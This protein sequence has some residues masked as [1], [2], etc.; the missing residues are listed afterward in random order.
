MN[1]FIGSHCRML[2]GFGRVR[3]KEQD[4]LLLPGMTDIGREKWH[5]LST[6]DSHQIVK[7]RFGLG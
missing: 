1:D 7:D 2:L 6:D 5:Q 3:V 4:L